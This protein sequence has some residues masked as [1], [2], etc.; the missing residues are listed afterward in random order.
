MLLQLT[1]DPGSKAISDFENQVTMMAYTIK[2][3]KSQTPQQFDP[4]SHWQ[5]GFNNFFVLQ[6]SAEIII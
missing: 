6:E 1:S 3:S 4:F 2:L 5:Q